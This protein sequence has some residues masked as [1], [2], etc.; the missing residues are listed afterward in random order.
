MFRAFLLLA[1]AAIVARA[2]VFTGA[3]L[4]WTATADNDDLMRLLSVRGWLDGQPWFDMRQY[5]MVP[6]EGLDLHWSRYVDA[7][8]GGLVV[9]FSGVMPR[10]E[11]ENIALVVWPSLLLGALVILTGHTARILFGTSAAILAVLSLILWPGIGAGNF[12]PYRIDH[13]NVQILLVAVMIFSLIVPGRPMLLGVLGGLAGAA[14]LAVG[15]EMLL[16]IGFVGVILVLRTVLAGSAAAGQLLGFGLALF[17]A[18]LVLFAGQTAPEVWGVARC[19]QLSPPHL[20][21]TGVA[22]LI[23]VALARVVAPLPSTGSRAIVTLALS[24]AGFAALLPVLSPCLAGPYAMLPPE[25]RA[26]V[27]DRIHEAQG[28]L[29]A[30]ESGNRMLFRVVLPAVFATL[31]AGAAF[32]V[33]VR[34]GLAGAEERRAM[35]VLLVF[36]AFGILGSFSQMRMVLLVAPAVPLLTGYGIVALLG[37]GTR[38]G[39]AGAARSLAAVACMFAT[40][41]LPLSDVAVQRALASGTPSSND[42]FVCRSGAALASLS[43]LPPGVILAPSDFGAPILLFSPHAAVAGPYHRSAAAF[44][45]GYLPFEGDE[46]GLRAAMERTGADYLLLCRNTTWEVE[47]SFARALAGGET[48]DWLE[49]VAGVDPRLVVLRRLQGR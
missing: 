29:T 33:R 31:V 41:F 6:P 21:L 48:A 16:T 37:N 27:H 32:A 19:D 5:R 25:A 1:L 7:A 24:A 2:V 35:S 42:H 46:A 47:T 40:I 49:P 17:P 8:I 22:A 23:A 4:G 34:T 10:P 14:S 3:P 43:A 13:H 18:S 36:G 26:I 20:A 44:V 11:A 9:L 28:V 30:L 39:L 38:S 45:D 15:L 12:A